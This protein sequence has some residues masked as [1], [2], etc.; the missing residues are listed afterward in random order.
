MSD[1]HATP[2][3]LPS[4]QDVIA[5]YDLRAEKSRGQNFILDMNITAQI[6]EHAAEHVED[7]HKY[8]IIEIGAGPG[9]LTRALLAAG[10]KRVIAIE[11]D[12]RFTPALQ[13][14]KHV[15]PNLQIE[16]ADAL[17]TSLAD[18]TDQP[19]K[20]VAN[21]PYNIS[22]SLLMKWLAESWH[23][24][25]WNP[26]FISLTLMFQKEVAERIVAPVGTSAYGR[27][28]IW[29]QWLCDAHIVLDLAPEVFVPAPKV[30][31]SV[32]HLIPRATPATPSD[33]TTDPAML[34][35]VL[36]NSFGQRR[37]MLRRSLKALCSKHAKQVEAVLAQSGISGE[38]RP[39][40]IDIA[41]FCRIAEALKKSQKEKTDD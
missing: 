15:Y 33:C 9:G 35:Q 25:Q 3:S 32:V 17:H 21:L 18:L 7:L 27:L 19:Y 39:E 22:T 29:T 38:A 14:I 13:D 8:D 16:T 40:V 28:S 30:H 11:A 37:K 41:G 20:V 4:L 34:S 2:N 6:A 5:K 24:N 26:Q 31:S 10:A 36:I 12:P 23:D 1:T